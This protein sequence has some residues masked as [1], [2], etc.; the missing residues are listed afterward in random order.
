M[1][2]G[3]DR[4]YFH[5][6]TWHWIDYD[7]LAVGTPVLIEGPDRF[8]VTYGGPGDGDGT[9]PER[10]VPVTQEISEWDNADE[11]FRYKDLPARCGSPSVFTDIGT[12][13]AF[14]EPTQWAAANGIATGGK[15]GKIRQAQTVT[16]EEM[17]VSLA[18]WGKVP[19]TNKID[20][21]QNFNI[22]WRRWEPSIRPRFHDVPAARQYSVEI[23]LLSQI[24]VINGR[25]DGTFRPAQKVTRGQ[26][27]AFLYRLAGSPVHS[28]P[29]ASTFKD[30][31][32]GTS[33]FPE[34][35]WMASNGFTTGYADK[36]F[37]PHATITRGEMLVMLHR[38]E[39]VYSGANRGNGIVE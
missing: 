23:S 36:T 34:I 24:G 15:D 39:K 20:G 7:C 5:G 29:Q 19:T 10:T 2:Y 8:M 22:D 31:R 26:A 13:H 3:V 21:E 27:S 37:R 25:A 4:T 16:R 17:A 32:P 9:G 18:R 38:L 1:D 14:Y 11:L 35:S 12:G 6:G 33:F 28:S 30:S